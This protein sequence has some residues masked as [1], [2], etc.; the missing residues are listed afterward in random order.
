MTSLAALS[1]RE[2][3]RGFAR[4]KSV[5]AVTVLTLVLGLSLCTTMACVLYGVILRPLS[6]GDA[7][8]LVMVWAGYEGGASERDSVN[9]RALPVW[10][11]ASRAFESVAGFGYVQFTLLER[12]EPASLQASM[13]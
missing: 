1:L 10:R 9:E 12:G 6:Y 7:R 13:V 8:R 3:A 11:Q 4:Q 2:A 5:F